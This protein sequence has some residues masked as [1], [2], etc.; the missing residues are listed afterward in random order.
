MEKPI[1]KRNVAKNGIEIYFSSKPAPEVLTWLKNQLYRWNKYAK[2]W[3]GTFTEEKWKAIFEFFEMS[4]EDP[5][6]QPEGRATSTIGARKIAR[7]NIYV[8]GT[9]NRRLLRQEL[10][11]GKMLYAMHSYFDPMTD[12]HNTIPRSEMIW[13]DVLDDSVKRELG[14]DYHKAHVY[15]NQEIIKGDYFFKYKDDV[16]IPDYFKPKVGT[17]TD[18]YVNLSLQ[19]SFEKYDIEDNESKDDDHNEGD[20][21]EASYFGRKICGEIVKKEI[22]RYTVTQW[23]GKPVE[24]KHVSYTIRLNNGV[25]ASLYQ[26]KKADE[27]SDIEPWAIYLPEKKEFIMP[28]RVWVEILESIKNEKYWIA[29]E[30]RRKK[31][32]YKVSDRTAAQKN[33]E[34]A[35][36]YMSLFLAWEL[37]NKEFSRKYIT[38]E[39]EQQQEARLTGWQEDLKIQPTANELPAEIQEGYKS[40]EVKEEPKS[41]KTLSE[42]LHYYHHGNLD[43]FHKKRA[44]EDFAYRFANDRNSGVRQ[45]LILKMTGFKPPK[46]KA[47]ITNLQSVIEDWIAKQPVPDLKPVPNLDEIAAKHNVKIRDLQEQMKIGKQIEMEHTDDIA[48]ATKIALQHLDEN[49]MYYTEGK[50]ENWAKKE[51]EKEGSTPKNEK[52]HV[53]ELTEKDPL[54]LNITTDEAAN[55]FSSYGLDHRQSLLIYELGTHSDQ[56]GIAGMPEE[57]AKPLIEADYLHK[58]TYKFTGMSVLTS[59]GRL[60]YNQGTKRFLKEKNTV[61]FPEET[62]IFTGP[63]EIEV[64]NENKVITWDD[65]PEWVKYAIPVKKLDFKR[66]ITDKNLVKIMS[67]YT[68]N[69]ALRPVMSGIYVDEGYIVA[70]DSM[71][72]IYLTSDS[73][74]YGNYCITNE[75]LKLLNKKPYSKIPEDTVGVFPNYKSIIPYDNPHHASF[76]VLQLKTWCEIIMRAKQAPEVSN[77]ACI[78]VDGLE[79]FFNVTFLIDICTTLLQLGH[80]TGIAYASQPFRPLIFVGP[81]VKDS[82]KDLAK[83]DLILTMPLDA[84]KYNDTQRKHF[85]KYDFKKQAC[86]DYTG[87]ESNISTKIT[88]AEAEE[89][90]S[91]SPAMIATIDKLTKKNALYITEHKVLVENGILRAT[92]L[93]LTIEFKTDLPDGFYDIVN[94]TILPEIVSQTMLKAMEGEIYEPSNVEDFPLSF[95]PER[96]P[97]H[98]LTLGTEAKQIIIDA[99][100]HL[101][102]DDLRPVLASIHLINHDGRLFVGASDKYSVYLVGLTAKENKLKEDF[103]SL[104]LANESKLLCDFLDI[105]NSNADIKIYSDKPDNTIG[106]KLVKIETGDIT[107][108]CYAP[109][110]KAPDFFGVLPNN[111]YSQRLTFSKSDFREKYNKFKKGT[112]SLNEKTLTFKLS[113]AVETLDAI[114][115][116]PLDKG[117]CQGIYVF[118]PREQ[119]ATRGKV[120]MLHDFTDQDIILWSNPEKDL[121]HLET[122]HSLHTFEE[123]PK[124]NFA[125]KEILAPAPEPKPEPIFKENTPIQEVRE[126]ENKYKPGTI[127]AVGLGEGKM[128]ATATFHGFTDDTDP[129][130]RLKIYLVDGNAVRREHIEFTMGGHGYVYPWIPIDEIWIDENLKDKPGDFAATLKHEVFEIRKMRDEGLTYDQAHELANVMEKKE[131]NNQGGSDFSKQPQMQYLAKLNILKPFISPVQLEHLGKMY[132][133]EEKEFFIE[134]VNGLAERI[135]NM[136]ATYETEDI[137]TKE[138]IVYLHYFS[139]SSDW[140]I[141]EKDKGSKDDAV[142][143]I[144]NQAFGYSIL[145]GDKMNAE[146]GYISI[147][148]LRQMN[149][150]LDF[151]W[152]PKKFSDIFEKEEPE[153][154]PRKDVEENSKKMLGVEYGKFLDNLHELD[155]WREFEFP[156]GTFREYRKFVLPAESARAVTDLG[157]KESLQDVTLNGKNFLYAIMS[158]KKGDNKTKEAME[159][160][161]RQD[162]GIETVIKSENN[163]IVLSGDIISLVSFLNASNDVKHKAKMWN[164][165]QDD[166]NKGIHVASRDRVLP[167]ISRTLWQVASDTPVFTE[168]VKAGKESKIFWNGNDLLNS[169]V[170]AYKKEGYTVDTT[171]GLGKKSNT[172]EKIKEGG[173]TKVAISVVAT[174]YKNPFELNVAIEALLDSK[175]N[176]P[177]ESWTG[178][179]LE[180]ISGYSGYGGLDEFGKVGVGSLFEFYTPVKV[181]EKMWGLAYKYGYKEGR[182]CEPSAGIGLFLKREFV[183]SSIIKDAYEINKY[184]AKIVRLLYPEVNVNNGKEVLYFEQLFIKNNYTVKDKITPVHELVIGNPPYGEAQ[185]LYMGMGEKTYTKA[186][187][188]IDYFIYRGLDL[189]VPGGL[190]VYIIGAEVAGGGVPWLDQG[191]SKCK[192]AI[193]KKGKLIDAYRLPEGIFAR[194]NVVSDIVV[195]RKR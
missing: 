109:E 118:I 183:K 18:Y 40:S 49:P 39:D 95:N 103:Y 173:D 160:A 124:M 191:N 21:I 129:E 93:S 52:P 100:P 37:D 27:C 99:K 150:E 43:D 153:V 130:D 174:D 182:L 86:I 175:W 142:P 68:G 102:D 126:A 14:D 61:K 167:K 131:R 176:D 3:Y 83:A 138:K 65:I 105:V 187:N 185:G 161:Y 25:E 20:R 145:N 66:E 38:G 60:L 125:T 94:K 30:K 5:G 57:V 51:L 31:E 53:T 56:Y 178:E 96:V 58:D 84:S 159:Q 26:F 75:C 149:V 32:S 64:P 16:T 67:P 78:I 4:V 169:I 42:L 172:T 168:V 9:I 2:F 73:K 189:L 162:T 184:S 166:D 180:F 152:D 165:G 186:K 132:R 82:K 63:E 98:I 123:V 137:P 17:K 141:V 110:A 54:L 192:E 122:E 62:K 74:E 177:V 116:E 50:P 134:L 194:T 28:D 181:I 139:G 193:A 1:V 147:E 128:G 47:G 89:K 85:L 69:D 76:D 155:L 36:K 15:E 106:T 46:V 115:V 112:L 158:V 11:D 77:A 170:K 135:T 33:K 7:I 81:G 107:L 104:P 140:Y 59:T 71:R 41:P 44:I 8:G 79:I 12:G 97:V 6:M 144:Q 195:F 13:S 87:K 171:P 143:G 29:S 10:E 88:K 90:L 111:N 80:T 35:F 24:Q 133:T 120:S 157:I 91:I 127:S 121:R 164:E 72:M 101:S 45:E 34:K 55:M 23:G 179:Q 163:E 117:N 119:A 156:E 114:K 48:L 108:Y 154:H 92:N 190:L 22:S 136:P 146:W 151:Y 113:D 70:T 19:P 148:E 188:Y